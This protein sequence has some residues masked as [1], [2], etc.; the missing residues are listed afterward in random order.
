M[1]RRFKQNLRP[2]KNGALAETVSQITSRMESHTATHNFRWVIPSICLLIAVATWVV[3][4]QTLGYEFV[5]VDDDIYVYENP[6]I[7]SGLTLQGIRWAFSN[8][9]GN[10]THSYSYY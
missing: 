5:N 8:S 10:F 6:R 9:Y 3:F 4:G 7:T 2:K 1:S